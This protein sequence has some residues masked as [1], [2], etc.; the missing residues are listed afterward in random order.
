MISQITF[1]SDAISLELP[2]PVWAIGRA[3][4][5]PAMRHLDAR[6]RELASVRPHAE[7]EPDPLAKSH[8]PGSQEWHT[9]ER[10][11]PPNRPQL[12][13]K[14]PKSAQSAVFEAPIIL[15]C[16]RATGMQTVG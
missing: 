15:R 10:K 1:K 6:R 5:A 2:C 8:Q 9:R 4:L 12:P 16:P 3:T 7:P 11:S 13:T 14:H